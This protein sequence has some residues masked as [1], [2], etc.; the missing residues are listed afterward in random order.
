MHLG[1]ASVRATGAVP[2]ALLVLL[3]GLTFALWQYQRTRVVDDLRDDAQMIRTQ[4]ARRLER[5]AEARI[6]LLRVLA[7]EA[8]E[9]PPALFGTAAS[10]TCDVISG[11]QGIARCD[12]AGLA[13]SN[14]AGSSAA[15]KAPA[16]ITAVADWRALWPRLLARQ[17]PVVSRV[18]GVAGASGYVLVLAPI[19]DNGKFDGAIVCRMRLSDLMDR[20]LDRSIRRDYD[21]RV[22]DG[23]NTAFTFD[24]AENWQPDP[25]DGEPIVFPGTTWTIYSRPNQALLD[26]ALRAR[27]T[28]ILLIGVA[29]AFAVAAA[30]WQANRYRMR[31]LAQARAHSNAVERLHSVAAAISAHAGS[32]QDVLQRLAKA[33][34]EL[35]QMTR[36][37]I[38]VLETPSRGNSVETRWRSVGNLDGAEL[39]VVANAGWPESFLG[40]RYALASLPASQLAIREARVLL[41][42]DV[43]TSDLPVNLFRE[44]GLRSGILIPL[45]IE[46]RV[47]GLLA[48]SSEQAREF[49]SDDQRLA[50]LWGAQAAVTLANAQLHQQARDALA[51]QR[52][53]LEQREALATATAAIYAEPHL[54]GTLREIAHRTPAVLGVDFCGVTLITPDN[55]ELVIAAATPP[56]DHVVGWRIKRPYAPVEA[57]FT[58]RQ[59]RI[60]EDITKEPQLDSVWQRIRSAGS[61]FN[62]PLYSSN[63]QPLGVLT[64][65]RYAKGSFRPDQ[66]ELA[67]LFAARAATAIENNRLHEQAHRDAETK[68][69]LLRELNHR[70]KNNLARIVGLLAMGEN[71][72]PE[73]AKPTLAR[74]AQR[75]RMMSGAHDLFAGGVDMISLEDL[76]QR[77][78]ASLS[79]ARPIGVD[80]RLELCNVG[81][82]L[83]TDRAVSLAMVLHE[84]AFNA[85]THGTIER[86]LMEIR[87]H[88][89]DDARLR[90][91]VLDD[92]VGIDPRCCDESG[93][94]SGNGAANQLDNDADAA[95]AV[96]GSSRT[97][98]GLPLVRGLVQRELGG[99]FEIRPRFAG[100]TCA[101]VEFPLTARERQKDVL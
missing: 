95:V 90:I 30:V 63:Q 87:A 24:G 13:I 52:Q 100:G 53:L 25:A 26:S 2:L 75:V 36:A 47:T 93:T 44:H 51:V 31:D 57:M 32:G 15:S 23:V 11:C 59:P 64:L 79:L 76:V 3:L 7:T 33:A 38:L 37:N 69:M 74:L 61:F 4:G 20:A 72:V 85:V 96:A 68:A 39:R 5:A 12:A 8:G 6:H 67:Q 84:L 55:E 50:E 14:F 49:T 9:F 10:S 21:I 92:G 98:L 54:E 16:D 65:V 34:C 60:V 66:L 28:P 91:E 88:V 58:A 94:S 70:V 45:Q 17:A 40:H 81:V 48:L 1:G 35:L 73:L 71:N 42:R 97:G 82:W 99:A 19:I 22:S 80:V 56:H 86:G 62:V 27:P 43:A 89:T 77:V 18:Y 29:A 46:G 101:G 78:L 83:N 41:I